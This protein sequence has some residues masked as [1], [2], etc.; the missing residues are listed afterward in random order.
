MPRDLG[1]TAIP[2]IASIVFGPIVDTVETDTYCD[3]GNKSDDKQT[4]ATH[5]S[6]GSA[7]HTYLQGIEK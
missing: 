1:V 3:V 7:C 6:S 4:R 5:T 2:A